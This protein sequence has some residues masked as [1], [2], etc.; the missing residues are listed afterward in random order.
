MLRLN[1]TKSRMSFANLFNVNVVIGAPVARSLA[2]P[3]SRL[4]D[5]PR[6]IPGHDVRGCLQ[7]LS[8]AFPIAVAG[9]HA[10]VAARGSRETVLRHPRAAHGCAGCAEQS[11]NRP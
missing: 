10:C 8:A 11:P 9:R 1:L 7:L 2:S 3:R 4:A 6:S 5:T